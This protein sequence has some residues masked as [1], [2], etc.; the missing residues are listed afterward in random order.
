MNE[1]ITII[2][3]CYAIVIVFSINAFLWNRR[4]EKR[5]AKRREVESQEWDNWLRKL[6]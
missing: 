3:I 5:Q 6:K 4:F 2:V 1:I